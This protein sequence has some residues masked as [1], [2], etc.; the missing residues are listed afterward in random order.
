MVGDI[1]QPTHLLLLLIVA[2]VVLGPKRLPEAGRALGNGLR[3][4]RA[5]ISGESR[6]DEPPPR[7]ELPSAEAPAAATVTPPPMVE[8]IPVEPAESTPAAT[9]PPAEP[10]HAA[11]PAQ[12]AAVA[13]PAPSQPEPVAE[14]AGR[15]ES[16]GPPR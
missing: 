13:E 1:L 11:E 3:D 12:P 4:F 16:S 7:E 2:L 6:Q 10:P 14:P 8:P 15:T 5:A 9:P